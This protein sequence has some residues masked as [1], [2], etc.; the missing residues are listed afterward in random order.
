MFKRYLILYISIL[1]ILACKEQ[2][3]N[4]IYK[5][6]PTKYNHIFTKIRALNDSSTINI[7]SSKGLID[8]LSFNS[9]HTQKKYVNMFTDYGI[10]GAE[11]QR[12]YFQYYNQTFEPVLYRFYNIEYSINF[13]NRYNSLIEPQNPENYFASIFI[14]GNEIFKLSLLNSSVITNYPYEI[15][16][17]Y[18]I[19][20]KIYSDVYSLNIMDASGANAIT[21]V[22][23]TLTEGVLQFET[24]ANEIFYIHL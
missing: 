23:F 6:I 19:E 22:Y 11:D 14:E 10:P 12:F 15:L 9:N 1:F 18:T 13:F 7:I 17:N 2:G 5:D 4:D 8:Q 20:G 16:S 24:N 21:K 3:P